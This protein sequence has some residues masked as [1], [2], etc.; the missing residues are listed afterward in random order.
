MER[1]AR[2]PPPR[3]DPRPVSS[4]LFFAYVCPCCVLYLRI[5]FIARLIHAP[6]PPRAYNVV[7]RGA[8]RARGAP[9]S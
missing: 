9:P 6:R 8:E 1:L 4:C 5:Y 3:L 2:P 7:L